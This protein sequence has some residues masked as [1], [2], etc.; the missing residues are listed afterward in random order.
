MSF[1]YL[2]EEM[3]RPVSRYVSFVTDSHRYDLGLF[4]TQHFDGKSLVM[5][6]QNM[7]AVLIS[8]DDVS[9]DGSWIETLNIAREDVEIVK[10]FLQKALSSLHKHVD[11]Y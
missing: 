1:E 4:Y 7:Q 11:Q 8:A 10:Q 6:L 3:E 9:H 2:Y 5:S